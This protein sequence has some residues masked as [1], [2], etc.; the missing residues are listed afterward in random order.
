M[1]DHRRKE[2]LKALARLL[3]TATE[4][5]KAALCSFCLATG[6]MLPRGLFMKSFSFVSKLRD[7]EGNGHLPTYEAL[8]DPRLS[9][10]LGDMWG[11][12]LAW[13]LDGHDATD[14]ASAGG[15][16][17]GELDAFL[18]ACRKIEI[19]LEPALSVPA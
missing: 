16:N 8:S 10:I 6:L 9:P 11:Q 12:T 19:D 17:R 3:E 2:D 14:P 4:R 18:R 13:M 5:Q 7:R 1:F 15:W